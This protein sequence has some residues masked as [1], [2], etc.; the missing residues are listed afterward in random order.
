MS[1]LPL[2]GAFHG[3][4]WWASQRCTEAPHSRQPRSRTARVRNWATVACRRVRPNHN[5]LPAASV[6]RRKGRAGQVVGDHLVA[7]RA[8]AVLGGRSTAEVVEPNRLHHGRFG[9]GSVW[10]RCPALRPWSGRR[11]SRERWTRRPVGVRGSGWRPLRQPVER[12]GSETVGT[13]LENPAGLG[14]VSDQ[15]PHR[16]TMPLHFRWFGPPPPTIRRQRCCRS[17]SPRR[18]R[19]PPR[20]WLRGPMPSAA[21][22]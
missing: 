7:D 5:G 17:S 4:T 12:H 18:C 3:T 21:R 14:P 22:P 20:T 9:T 19:P 6:K 16:P 2:A 15:R 11:A 1:V 10:R 13:G 8:G